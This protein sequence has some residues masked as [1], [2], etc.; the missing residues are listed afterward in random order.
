MYNRSNVLCFDVIAD[1]RSPTGNDT[2]L[3]GLA[4]FSCPFKLI[5][6]R[7]FKRPSQILSVT[8]DYGIMVL[9]FVRSSKPVVLLTLTH[10]TLSLRALAEYRERNAQVKRKS[11]LRC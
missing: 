8:T 7:F 2:L 11:L 1:G 10:S 4:N 9:W 5:Q 3:K 6:Y